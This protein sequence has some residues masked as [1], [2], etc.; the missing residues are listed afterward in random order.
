MQRYGPG[1]ALI[2]VDVQNDFAD[3][4][5]SLS[6]AG[7][8]MRSSR[9][10]TARSSRPAPTVP[11]VVATQDW[12]PPSTPHFAKDGGI[13]PVHCVADT[14]GAALYP[15]LALPDD[16][17]RVRKGING[18]DG[19]SGLHDARSADRRDARRP[20]STDSCATPAWSTSSPSASRPTTASMRRRSMR[21]SSAIG[22][23]CSSTP[24]PRSTSE[25]ATATGQ[26]PGCEAAGVGI[27]EDGD[28]MIRGALRLALAGA[29]IS[30]AID[31]VL[32]KQSAGEEPEPIKSM[33]VIDAPIERVWEAV[34]DIEGQPRWMHDMKAVR[35]QTTGPGRGRHG[36][37]GRC[38]DPRHLG[39]RPGP[40]HGVRAAQPVRD[41][42]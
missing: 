36:R 22:P 20:S 25:R 4:A 24:A 28:A 2:V 12:H 13:W 35:L 16:A 26:W 15:D 34:A 29:G 38:P 39:H 37:R 19:Y 9:G 10:S 33:V 27:T 8:A 32:A 23:R 18:E 17:P 14:W 5:G 21:S 3:P 30:Y 6:V 40:H 1:S 11:L 41:Q 31:R 42:P 7:A